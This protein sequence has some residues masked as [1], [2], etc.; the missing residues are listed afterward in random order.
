VIAAPREVAF[1]VVAAPYL[2]R[3]PRA[4]ESKLHVLERAGDMV[5]AAHFTPLAGTDTTTVETVRF[6]RP[7]AIHFRLVRGTVPHVA[8]RFALEEESAGGTVLVWDGELA[9]DLWAPGRLW[10]ALVARKWEAVVRDSLAGVKAEAELR[11]Q[12]PGP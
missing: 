9:T 8:E 1:D 11:S 3:T 5:L 7:S 10:G 12:P 4:L 6:E 2:G